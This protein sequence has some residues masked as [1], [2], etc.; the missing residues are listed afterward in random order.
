MSYSV[1]ALLGLEF[2]QQYL[3]VPTECKFRMR[4]GLTYFS[5]SKL[6]A[7]TGPAGEPGLRGRLVA[8]L[9]VHL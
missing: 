2:A 1:F 3:F 9:L 4:V 8:D 7:N 5:L 6:A